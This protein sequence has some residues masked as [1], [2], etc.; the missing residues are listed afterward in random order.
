MILFLAQATDALTQSAMSGLADKGLT[1]VLLALAVWYLNR[2]NTSLVTKLDAANL[3][4]M[5]EKDKAHEKRIEERG[6]RMNDLQQQIASLELHVAD[7]NKDRTELWKEILSISKSLPPM[8]PSV[9]HLSPKRA[10][11]PAMIETEVPLTQ[12]A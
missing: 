12:R 10:E 4:A 7:C 11:I 6:L 2:S 1:A 8:P 9:S 5:E 3:R